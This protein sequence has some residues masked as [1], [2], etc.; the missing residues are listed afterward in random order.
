MSLSRREAR[1][2]D[3]RKAI[4]L[5]A[6]RA[7]LEEGYAATSMSGLLET[8]GGSK[9]TLWGYFPSKEELFTAVIEDL[10]AGFR[11]EVEDEFR[12]PAGLETTLFTFCSSF[13][14]R[15]SDPDTVSAWRLIVGETARFPEL[16]RIFY[17]KVAKHVEAALAGYL[18]TQ[19]DA[20]LLRDEGAE[21]MAQVLIGL[22]ESQ[23]NRS[24]WGQA[25]DRDELEGDA[26][27]FTGYFLQIFRPA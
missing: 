18:V 24:I 5:A 6:K 8:L 23:Q 11:K 27:R 26:R 13:V 10:T 22:C 12:A 2:L 25:F 19:I 15:A 7:F 1:K 14:H 20:G 4:V 16:G 9:A 21:W 17:E 3:R